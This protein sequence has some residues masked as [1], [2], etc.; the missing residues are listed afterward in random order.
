MFDW[1]NNWQGRVNESGASG[2]N[3]ILGDQYTSLLRSEVGLRF[4]EALQYSWGSL[5][6]LEKGSWV[7]RLPFHAGSVQTSFVGSISSF[8]IELFSDKTENLGAIELNVQFLPG[9]NKHP[10]GA[11]NYQGEFSS[12]Y[13][14]HLISLEIGK[15]F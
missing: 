2:F 10:Y 12:S 8:S 13:Q 6:L 9:T 11:I 15:D 7:T 1:A 5:L 14:N 4:F 3:V